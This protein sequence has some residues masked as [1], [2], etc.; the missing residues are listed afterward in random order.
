M[1][2]EPSDPFEDFRRKQ[3]EKRKREFAVPDKPRDLS[4]V[5]DYFVKPSAAPAR[6]SHPAAPTQAAVPVPVAAP[7][8]AAPVARAAW[9]SLLALLVDRGVLT[10]DEAEALKKG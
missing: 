2:G 10:R 7:A 3:E 4:R 9:E 8:L 6:T 1:A 5:S